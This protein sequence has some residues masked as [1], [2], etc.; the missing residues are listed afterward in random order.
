[1]KV[2]ADSRSSRPVFQRLPPGAERLPDASPAPRS[3]LGARRIPKLPIWRVARRLLHW[4]LCGAWFLGS[5]ALDRMR[6]TGSER[7]TGERLRQVFERMGA[8]AIKLGQQ[9]SVRVDLIPYAICEELKKLTDAVPPM[10][11]G[12]A[13]K[14][15][16]GALREPVESVFASIDPVPIGSASIACV[17]VGTLKSGQR[18]AIKVKRPQVTEW[19]V[20]DLRTLG[21][22]TKF[23]EAI[24][25]VPP[26]YFR[27]MRSEFYG[28]F[29]EELDFSAEARYQSLF[30]KAAR[31]SGLSWLTAPRAHRH[32]SNRNV[33]VSDFVEGV[34]CTELLRAFETGDAPAI[35]R[36]RALD[37]DPEELGRRIL[38]MMFWVKW[39]SPFFHSDPHPGNL[40]FLSGNRIA[41]L[42]FGSCGVTTAS[43][44]RN[45]LMICELMARHRFAEASAAAIQE[46]TPLPR[47]EIS[48]Y[49]REHEE[50]LFKMIL[51][52]ED[53]RAEWWERT[54]AGLWLSFTEVVQKYQVPMNLN[55]LRALRAALL[56]DTL[57]C[58]LNP[59]LSLDEFSEYAK[60]AMKRARK[61][62]RGPSVRRAAAGSRRLLV[63]GVSLARNFDHLALA[64]AR[65]QPRAHFLLSV[66]HLANLV[67]EAFSYAVTFLLTLI[68]GVAVAGSMVITSTGSLTP[69]AGAL[70]VYEVLT[71][72]IFIALQIFLAFRALR[73]MENP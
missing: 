22:L 37:L 56:Y 51:A 58:R 65:R 20:A 33:L 71:H 2:E 50:R 13:M 53:K 72:P 15:L 42:D 46:S 61:R 49:L 4:W 5:A 36:Y 39:E 10:A 41:M 24:T 14:S 18:V 73:R 35:A 8:S 69:S 32:L 48:E 45:Q 63:R 52:S 43:S 11:F 6:G 26:D 47:V 25:A 66:G 1:M 40:I 16:R 19:L 21:L 64:L 55:G 57:A 31:D 34:A 59:N 28:M 70:D 3:D 54:W 17:Y 38:H 68:G 30:R 9:L 12:D 23:L 27:L 44:N 29:L 62:S 7:R 67:R 60:G